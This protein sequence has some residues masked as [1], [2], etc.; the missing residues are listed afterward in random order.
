MRQDR[1]GHTGPA[2]LGWWQWWDTVHA[3][4]S[5]LVQIYVNTSVRF[6]LGSVPN[7]D[8][9]SIISGEFVR[10]KTI[11]MQFV[12]SKCFLYANRGQ[13]AGCMWFD[14]GRMRQRDAIVFFVSCGP[15]SYLWFLMSLFFMIDAS[16]L[17]FQCVLWM[18]WNLN[19]F[20]ANG[21]IWGGNL[22]DYWG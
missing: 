7:N 16:P 3:A 2:E 19:I 13:P 8:W 11:F 21:H 22:N 6:G 5:L 15:E 18:L 17:Q 20:I 1:T 12:A 4:V 10:G 14:C 9:M